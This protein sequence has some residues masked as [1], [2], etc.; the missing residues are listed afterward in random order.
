MRERHWSQSI[1]LYVHKFQFSYLL[2]L[3]LLPFLCLQK[4]NR[5]TGTELEHNSCTWPNTP[6]IFHSAAFERQKL[7]HQC[8]L[9]Y[10]EKSIQVNPSYFRKEILCW[11]YSA[12]SKP[13]HS[14]VP[15]VGAINW[16]WINSRHCDQNH[17]LNTGE[18]ECSLLISTENKHIWY[19][20][21]S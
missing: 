6:A 8:Q 21:K 1:S 2:L 4:K 18:A 3:L 19:W 20:K 14:S 11:Y 16:L 15:C 12:G 7:L 17:A 10:D 9:I 13:G 5:L